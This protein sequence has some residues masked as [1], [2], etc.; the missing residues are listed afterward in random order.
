MLGIL[1]NLK[2]T[3]ILMLI[4]ITTGLGGYAS[5]LRSENTAL[6]S[7]NVILTSSAQ[8][9]EQLIQEKNLQITEIKN[10]N[11]T[12]LT[13]SNEQQKKIDNLNK[14]FVTMANGESRDFGKISVAKPELIQKIVNDGTLEVLECVEIASG[15]P[16]KLPSSKNKSC[17]ELTKDIA[18]DIK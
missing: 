3:F 17:P 11:K 8:K 13:T 5:F 10:I 6:Q 9:Q 15:K 1:S 14:K 16:T 18:K 2:N 12:L 4:I 7:K